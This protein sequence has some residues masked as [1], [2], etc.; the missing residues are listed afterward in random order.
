MMPKNLPES[1]YVWAW[2]QESGPWF[3]EDGAGRLRDIPDML[4]H[5]IG[6]LVVVTYANLC[7]RPK[8]NLGHPYNLGHTFPASPLPS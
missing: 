4:D 1:G 5:L 6:V 8:D 7:S 3:L 2:I